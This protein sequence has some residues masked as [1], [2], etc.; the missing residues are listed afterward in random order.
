MIE[1]LVLASLIAA[2]ESQSSSQESVLRAGVDI[3]LHSTPGVKTPD[4][5][6]EAER[7]Y[8][9]PGEAQVECR[10]DEA[11]RLSACQILSETPVGHAFGDHAVKIA[12][13]L[14]AAPTTVSGVP[15]SGSRIS[16]KFKF[17]SPDK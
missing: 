10:I 7:R 2:V 13:S 14:S 12:Q 9:L 3:K 6:P 16:L 5:Y 4:Y 11:L 15:S 1:I 8:G 17:R